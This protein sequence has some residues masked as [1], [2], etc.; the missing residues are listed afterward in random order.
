MLYSTQY[1][2]DQEDIY[3][4]GEAVQISLPIGEKQPLDSL[5]I[6]RE[7]DQTLM[8]DKGLV[9]FTLDCSIRDQITELEPNIETIAPRWHAKVSQA[10]FTPIQTYITVDWSVDPD[11]M[12]AY[13]DENGEGFADEDGN[14]YWMYNGMDAVG[15]EVQ[16]LTLVD[17]NGVPV[18]E[19]TEG[20][21]GNHGISPEQAWFTFPYA[22]T[23]PEDLYLAPHY[24]GQTDMEYAVRI[25]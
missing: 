22:E 4:S 19:T 10:V 8:P 25:R 2:L 21:Y 24:N 23:L 17:G 5:T 1:R 14:I 6:D 18:F 16:S 11:V 15:T 13:I 3:L 7:N 12:Q 9:T 20:F